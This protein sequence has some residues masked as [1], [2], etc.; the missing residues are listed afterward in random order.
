MTSVWHYSS[1]Y[2]PRN[3]AV[4]I[5]VVIIA[6]TNCAQSCGYS[7]GTRGGNEGKSGIVDRKA[8]QIYSPSIRTTS[9]IHSAVLPFGSTNIYVTC[10]VPTTKNCPG[11]WDRDCKVATPEL[12]VAVG[13][14]QDTIAPPVLRPVVADTSSQF[15][16]TGL[17]LSTAKFCRKKK[18]KY[19][20][21]E[22]N[23]PTIYQPVLGK[24]T[25]L[26]TRIT[27]SIL[28]IFVTSRY[29]NQFLSLSYIVNAAVSV[30][31]DSCELWQM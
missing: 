16:I 4:R 29:E 13:S 15:W 6:T 11:V 9:K 3:S 23:C 18:V 24:E 14:I 20:N 31:F 1:N 7:D 2:A 22:I 19:S 17:V 10:V 8:L 27:E 30:K 25:S 21:V 5:N 12:S 26:S 28:V